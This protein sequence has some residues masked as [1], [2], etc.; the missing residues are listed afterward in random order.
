M[1]GL[2]VSIIEK[3]THT[4]VVV[5]SFISLMFSAAI[6]FVDALSLLSKLSLLK[7]LV[8]WMLL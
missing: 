7:S 3:N 6:L 2:I 1:I 4:P 5:Y 8:C